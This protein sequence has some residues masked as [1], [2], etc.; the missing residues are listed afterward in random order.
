[1]LSAAGSVP[2][3]DSVPDAVAAS[4]AGAALVAGADSV[5]GDISVA[6]GVVSS[7]AG[8]VASAGPTAFAL[9]AAS[10]V[11]PVPD[12]PTPL[13]T[14]AFAS[15][16]TPVEK[17]LSFK[18]SIAKQHNRIQTVATPTVMRVNR[19]PALVP[20]ALW[21]PAPPSAPAIPPPRPR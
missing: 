9:P 18:T 17:S 3:A 20:K 8:A 19:S 11:P 4:V 16:V 6:A 10:V 13:A 15:S 21:P 5:A 7:A 12:E 1:M 2:A 14:V